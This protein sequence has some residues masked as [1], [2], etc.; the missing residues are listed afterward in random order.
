MCDCVGIF[1]DLVTF[2]NALNLAILCDDENSA[3]KI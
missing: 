3:N 1:A 2:S